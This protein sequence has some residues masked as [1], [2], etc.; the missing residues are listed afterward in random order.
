[1]LSRSAQKGRH[2]TERGDKGLE[3]PVRRLVD[4]MVC[5]GSLATVDSDTPALIRRVL[6]G[7]PARMPTRAEFGAIFDDN[8]EP[9]TFTLG[10][11]ET[12]PDY[13]SVT[14]K[15]SYAD[16]VLREVAEDAE[17]L[18]PLLAD[19]CPWIVPPGVSSEELARETLELL[20]CRFGTS[21]ELKDD[22]Y[23]QEYSDVFR[24]AVL[25]RLTGYPRLPFTEYDRLNSKLL[26]LGLAIASKCDDLELSVLM[27]VSVAC[28]LVG[29]NHKRSAAAA[30]PLHSNRIIPI[31]LEGPPRDI[32]E[33][34]FTE[35]L[36][37]VRDGWAIDCEGKFL[38]LLGGGT[39]QFRLVFFTDDYL[40]TIIDM[41]LIEKLLTHFPALHVRVVPRANRVGNDASS[42]DLRLLLQM[43][44]FGLL[45]DF[46]T[47]GRFAVE[48]MG[49]LSG[50]VNGRYLSRPVVC[51]LR[52][53]DAVVVKGARSFESLQGM[54]KNVFFS[55]AVCR[56]LS[57]SVTG[58]DAET[59]ALVLIH[60]PPGDTSFA[61]FRE[62]HKR[63]VRNESGRTMWLASRTTVDIVG[64][65][66][67]DA[68]C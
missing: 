65:G 37:R 1:M 21:R 6:L 47:R 7:A 44:S 35:L 4:Q 38:S 40:E 5:S 28:G 17:R 32:A 57:E 51:H 29:L 3:T 61:G 66:G 53:A 64:R 13:L 14:D 43:P 49:P 46:E 11:R 22:T 55:F 20:A 67:S 16:W 24:R 30:S 19:A 18:I 9:G 54:K 25:A 50:N 39:G 60:Q 2:T 41:K 15:E 58:I 48:A 23:Q 36:D 62:R 59:G 68:S 31:D 34:V 45:K 26:N 42:C 8:Y 56:S 52:G 10:E 27:M 12:A 63:A 33:S